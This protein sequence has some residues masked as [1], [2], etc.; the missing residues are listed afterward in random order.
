[1]ERVM[2]LAQGSHIERTS[3]ADQVYDHLR[4]AVLNGDLPQGERVIEARIAKSLG[5]S[6]AP[7]REAVNRL[8]QDGLLE[9]RTHFGASVIQMDAGK[10]RHLYELRSAIEELA[11]R[12]VVERREAVDLEPL[13]ACVAEMRRMARNG[14][15]RRLVEAEVRAHGPEQRR[16]DEPV[17]TDQAESKAQ[18]ERRLPFIG[19]VVSLGCCH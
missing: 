9:A 19:R 1:M 12:K 17:Q 10:I 4:E 3:I 11:I 6:R 18:D 5:I 2:P 15:L 16:Q 7:V 8:I 13:R 14:D